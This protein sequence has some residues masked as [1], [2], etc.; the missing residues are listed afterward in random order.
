[1]ATAR[2]SAPPVVDRGSTSL[3]EVVEHLSRAR[4]LDE[5]QAVVSAAARR[6]TGAD[7][8]TF[9]L[10]IDD[11]CFYADEDAVA[12]LWKGQRFP[13]TACVSGWAMLNRRAAV[14]PDIYDDERV[15]IDAYRPTFVKSLVMVPVR[16]TDPLGAIGNYWAEHHDP[17]AEEMEILQALA[18]C[19]AIAVEH[20]RVLTELEDRIAARTTELRERTEQAERLTAEV[21]RLAS[22]DPLT[23][24]MNRRGFLASVQGRRAEV[25]E[26][27]LVFVD[28]DGLKGINDRL[29]HEAGDEVIAAGADALRRAIG[30]DGIV[31]RWGGDEFVVHA[32]GL[33]PAALAERIVSCVETLAPLTTGPLR[34]SAGFVVDDGH[35]TLDELIAE[36]DADMYAGRRRRQEAR[37]ISE[38]SRR[39]R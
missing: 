37:A 38:G 30:A 23:G 4:T 34:L 31:G 2:S 32:T 21:E 19:A 29:G 33:E 11:Q 25:G 3:I 27:V 13:L 35:R 22:T 8:A 12:P 7:G 14:I 28:V 10:R 18:N 26:G 24:A 6:L 9:V 16:P 36:A 20:V 1:M 15:P 39:D 17:T 5:V